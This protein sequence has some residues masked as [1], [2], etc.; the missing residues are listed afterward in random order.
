MSETPFRRAQ[1]YSFLSHT[2]LYPE[3][4]WL[5]EL[6]LLAG[7][8]EDLRIPT[9]REFRAGAWNI[10][11]EQLRAEHRLAFGLTGS[12]C[13]E[14]ESGLPHEYR[15]SQEMADIAGFY[16]AFGFQ[17]GGLV[18]ERPDH[19]SV[20]L[21]FLYVLCLKEAYAREKGTAE[22]VEVCQ[23]ARAKFLQDHLGQWIGLFA[24]SLER[25]TAERSASPEEDSPYLFLAR[26][27]EAF[28][29]ADADGLGV[30]IKPRQLAGLQLTPLPADLSCGDCPVPQ[31]QP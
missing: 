1:V 19:L 22:Q 16:R 9:A 20:E 11:L 18:R 27:T 2:F 6:P 21:E 23:E 8:W 12:L 13:Y 3:E 4:N 7:I 24:Q 17:V 10:S 15:Q 26:L 14:T 25:S 28:I 30:V 31:G 5:E 29:R